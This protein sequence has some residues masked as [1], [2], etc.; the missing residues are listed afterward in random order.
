M[1]K[2]IYPHGDIA[3]L[4]KFLEED[5]DKNYRF[6]IIVTDGVFSMEGYLAELPKLKE[7]ADKYGTLLFVDDA[8]AVGVLGKTGAGTPEHFDLH[9]KIDI[10]S[11]TFSKSTWRG[12]RRVYRRTKRC[13]GIA[14]SKISHIPF[15]QFIVS[16]YGDG[17]D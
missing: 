12:A 4:H 5:I 6:K 11:G 3:T 7:L 13:S 15:F 10:L 2:R 8:H 9:G 14:P 1:V 17:G 16:I